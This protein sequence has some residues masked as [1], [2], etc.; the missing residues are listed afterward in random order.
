MTSSPQSQQQ[1]WVLTSEAAEM[2]GYNVNYVQKLAR[3][4]WLQDEAER[5]IKL[6]KRGGQYELWLPDLLNYI[7]EHGYGP[8][9]PQN[10]D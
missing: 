10:S 5:L 3:K 7:K 2:T 8:R 6:R 9:N 4:L 1:A